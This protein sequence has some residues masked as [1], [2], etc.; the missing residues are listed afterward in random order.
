[1]SVIGVTICLDTDAEEHG[2]LAYLDDTV[3][4]NWISEKLASTLGLQ[5]SPHTDKVSADWH[6][7]NL[8]SVGVVT[9]S[10]FT[11]D[12]ALPNSY[13]TTFHVAEDDS[14]HIIF[15]N[16]LL[17]KEPRIRDPENGVL[18]LTSSKEGTKGKTPFRHSRSIW[19]T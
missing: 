8:Q 18:I 2:D 11:S 3:Q 15:G 10:W 6:G 17:S 16:E 12:K 7:R 19:K 4:K 1:M 9:F 14:V 5:A 13:T